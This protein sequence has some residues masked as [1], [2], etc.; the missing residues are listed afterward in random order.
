M[1]KECSI[2]P[3][4]DVGRED[5]CVVKAGEEEHGRE[6]SNIDSCMKRKGRD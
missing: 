5:V 6:E 4:D 3:D 1:F 2:Y